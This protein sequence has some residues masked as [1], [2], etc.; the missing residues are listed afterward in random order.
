M[1]S[2][3]FFLATTMIAISFFAG[4]SSSSVESTTKT[5]LTNLFSVSLDTTVPDPLP[6]SMGRFFVGV[7]AGGPV[8]PTTSSYLDGLTRGDLPKTFSVTADFPTSQTQSQARALCNLTNG[9][10]LEGWIDPFEVSVAAQGLTKSIVVKYYP[11]GP[12][13]IAK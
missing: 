6:G 3:L 1:R 9:G 11:P 2:F 13:G 10:R 5:T 7:D 8:F 12:A 4:C